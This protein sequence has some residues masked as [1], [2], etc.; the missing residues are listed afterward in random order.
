MNRTLR[1]AVIPF[2]LTVLSGCGTMMTRS[3]GE[4]FGAYPLE[5]P[6]A[7]CMMIAGG[8]GPSYGKALVFGLVSLPV[9]LALDVALCPVDLLAWALGTR[10]GDRERSDEPPGSRGAP[11]PIEG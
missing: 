11:D 9:D 10:K 4:P 6:L 1:C 7:D 8:Y 5:A 3:S 2:A